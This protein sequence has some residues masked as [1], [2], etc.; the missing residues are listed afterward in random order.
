MLV[1]LSY[2]ALQARLNDQMLILLV[3]A[4]T[5]RVEIWVAPSIKNHPGSG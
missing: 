4:L 2:G 5:M 3:N 1:P